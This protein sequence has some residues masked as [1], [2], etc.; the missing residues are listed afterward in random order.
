M[1]FCLLAVLLA[2]CG[3]EAKENENIDLGKS[4]REAVILGAG[5]HLAPGEKD[6]YYCS[7]IL[8]VWEPLVTHAADGTPQPALAESWEMLDGGRTWIFHL[9]RNVRFHNGT[10]F[11]ADA[12]LA[13][14]ARMAKG[15]KRSNYYGLDIKTYYPSLLRYEK[16]DDYTVRLSFAEANVNELYKMMD[17]GSPMYAPECFAE[18]GNFNGFAIGTGPYRITENRLGKYVVLERSELYYGEKAHIPRLIVKNIPNPEVRYAALK[19]GEIWGV[20]DINAIPPFLAD[21]IKKDG[22]FAVSENKSTMIRFLTVNGGRFPF[23]DVRMRQAVS[24]AIDRRD[25]AK[26]LYLNYCE[27]TSNII[28][29]TSPYYT[30][31]PVEYDLQKARELARQVL[32]GRRA[33]VTY[34]LNGAEP[35]Q[36]GEAELIAYWLKEIGLDVTI[37]SLEYATMSKIMRKGDYDLARQQQGLPNGDPYSI[38]YSLMMPDGGR[39]VASS[40]HYKNDEVIALLERV[41]HTVDEAER[42]RIYGRLQQ[43]SV[44]EQP[45]IPLFN[46]KTIVAYDKHLKNYEALVYGVNLSKVEL[47]E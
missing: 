3:Q 33:S 47:A 19:A 6:G 2:G 30:A 35:L 22:R 10:P 5:R 36:K 14:F 4:S 7:K 32:G 44:D 37:R 18:D 31:I 40:L 45:V 24:L 27:P 11:N 9:R 29:Y 41:K 1:L 34:C 46:D 25:I 26:A 12:V 43:I 23:N 39:A 21:E 17:F 38:F 15:Y 42:R 28:N 20:L 8:G 16:L 13:N